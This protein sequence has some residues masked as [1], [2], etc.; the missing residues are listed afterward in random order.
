[1][2]AALFLVAAWWLNG[3]IS[4]KTHFLEIRAENPLSATKWLPAKTKA[5]QKIQPKNQRIAK[6]GNGGFAT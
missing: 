4:T 5:V 6:G 3:Q 2:A 1:M